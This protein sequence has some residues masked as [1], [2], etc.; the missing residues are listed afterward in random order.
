MTKEDEES[1]DR[2]GAIG[3]RLVSDAKGQWALLF[4]QFGHVI[5]V[6]MKSERDARA[7]YQQVRRAL[8]AH[9]DVE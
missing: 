8:E 9:G 4:A 6:P 2:R 7:C 3:V 1:E 5:G